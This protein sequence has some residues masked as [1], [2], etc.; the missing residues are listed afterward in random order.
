MTVGNPLP[1]AVCARSISGQRRSITRPRQIAPAA[2]RCAWCGG[3]EAAA[4][5]LLYLERSDVHAL[6][7]AHVDRRTVIAADKRRASA[8]RTEVMLQFVAFEGVGVK[9]GFGSGQPQ[10]DRRHEPVQV[11]APGA[12][13]AVAIHHFAQLALDLERN[14]SAMASALV[15]HGL[16][17]WPRGRFRSRAELNLYL[18]LS[19]AQDERT[20]INSRPARCHRGG[21]R[22]QLRRGGRSD[23]FGARIGDGVL[24]DAF[25]CGHGVMLYCR[26]LC[27]VLLFAKGAKKDF[28]GACCKPFTPGERPN[29][30]GLK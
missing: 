16:S 28:T 11:A 12:D 2:G 22:A 1:A 25:D 21:G 9:R 13:R 6:Q 29:M 23:E 20:K 27:R 17:P 24:H 26:F 14:P 5:E 4:V 30:T 3:S 7:A 15:R 10:L 8:G 18:T 19:R